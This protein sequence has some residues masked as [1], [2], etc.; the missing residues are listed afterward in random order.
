MNRRDW[1][2]AVSA[3]MT[4]RVALPA[5]TGA[6]VQFRDITLTAGLGNARNVSGSPDN[7][8]YLPE[9]MGCGAAI[10]DYD[11]DG[12]PDIFLV[13]GSTFAQGRKPTSYLFHNNGDG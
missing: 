1:L 10:I 9:E 11:N 2:R 8:Q 3:W 4:S 7:K 12:W 6:G 5:V 13:N